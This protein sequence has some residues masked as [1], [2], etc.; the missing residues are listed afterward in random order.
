LILF[1]I[2]IFIKMR[3]G[4]LLPPD[5]EDFIS[6]CNKYWYANLLYFNNLYP[7]NFTDSVST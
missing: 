7:E 3:K 6:S 5:K 2:S 1:S 4:P